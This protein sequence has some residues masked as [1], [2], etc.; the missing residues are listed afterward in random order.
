MYTNI[1]AHKV[2][3][4]S[5]KNVNTF[6]SV[7]S[8]NDRKNDVTAKLESQYVAVANATAVPTRCIG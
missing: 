2:N 6:P 5:I 4:A 7:V 8:I 1:N 3:P